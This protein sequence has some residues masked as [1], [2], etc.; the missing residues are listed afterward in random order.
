VSHDCCN[1][2]YSASRAQPVSPR[3]IILAQGL[4]LVIIAVV[5]SCFG[6][7]SGESAAWGGISVLAPSALFAALFFYR[8]NG[9]SGLKIMVI[10]Y[11]GEIVK[12]SFTAAL[13]VIFF[14][15]FS[16]SLL[17]LVVGVISVSLSM[18]FAPILPVKWLGKGK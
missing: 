4:M 7:L 9:R 5:A 6:S 16:L 18:I 15:V 2:Q 11:V 12:L 3:H 1:Q 13:A 10:F 8:A 14:N 17:P